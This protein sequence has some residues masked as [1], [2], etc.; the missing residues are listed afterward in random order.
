MCE[1]GIISFSPQICFIWY[2]GQPVTQQY[3]LWR[4]MAWFTNTFISLLAIPILYGKYIS[5]PLFILLC[6]GS[7]VFIFSKARGH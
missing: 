3:L 5:V 6:Y 2:D 4:L 7:S 1:L